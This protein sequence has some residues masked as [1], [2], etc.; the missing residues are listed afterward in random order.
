[1]ETLTQ[2]ILVATDF[3]EESMLAL[4]AAAL[5]A[6]QNEAEVVLAHVF[7][8][9]R[10]APVVEKPDGTQEIEKQL[11]AELHNQLRTLAN[12]HFSNVTVKT[13]LVVSKNAAD[14]ICN[15]AADAEVDLIVVATHGRS[16]LSHLLIGSVA[17]KV[18]RHAPCPVLSLRA[19]RAK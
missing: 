9:S 16:G 11:R 18:V 5:L 1:M 10:F 15:Y 2:K 6:R 19:K 17:E 8:A 7:E 14:G 3:S 13:A 4:D 12:D